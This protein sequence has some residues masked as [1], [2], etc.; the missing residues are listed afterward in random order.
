ML[1]YDDAL[2]V[3]KLVN[4]LL[5]HLLDVYTCVLSF[6]VI[7]GREVKVNYLLPG[8]MIKKIYKYVCMYFP[9]I[10]TTVSV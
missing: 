6:Y 7:S 2:S 4:S 8:I 5:L 3:C 9:T 1:M 10:I